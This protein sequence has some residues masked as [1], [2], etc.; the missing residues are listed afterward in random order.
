MFSLQNTWPTS[1]WSHFPI[2]WVR[3]S[4]ISDMFW[5]Q[6]K[7]SQQSRKLFARDSAQLSEGDHHAYTWTESK[8]LV[9]FPTHQLAAPWPANFQQSPSWWRGL[10]A[11]TAKSSDR[12]NIPPWRC[13]LQEESTWSGNTPTTTRDLCCQ[14]WVKNMTS[15]PK[16]SRYELDFKMKQTRPTNI[17]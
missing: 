6:H 3:G 16:K 11:C 5:R 2:Y 15:H 12:R 17:L 14:W 13:A 7:N 8:R 9:P 1:R 4:W 10:A